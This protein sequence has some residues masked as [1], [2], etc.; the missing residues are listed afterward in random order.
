MNNLTEKT[1][2]SNNKPTSKDKQLIIRK[3]MLSTVSKKS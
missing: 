2:W 1:N 3:T